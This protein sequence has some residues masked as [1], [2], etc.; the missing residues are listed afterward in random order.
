MDDSIKLDLSEKT[1]KIKLKSWLNVDLGIFSLSNQRGVKW[2]GL[3]K[4]SVNIGRT[5]H[6]KT[7]NSVK[8]S[9]YFRQWILFVL[10]TMFVI[11]AISSL[12]R[13]LS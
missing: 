5:M 7:V 10:K 12:V 11:P 1:A 13:M 9:V 3:D 6:P 8:D 4:K 2:N